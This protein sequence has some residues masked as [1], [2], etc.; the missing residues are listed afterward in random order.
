MNYG[1]NLS[2]EVSFYSRIVHG[3]VLTI[4]SMISK[5]EEIVTYIKNVNMIESKSKL[6]EISVVIWTNLRSVRYKYKTSQFGLKNSC[7]VV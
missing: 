7:V 4:V 1:I 2:T 5:L 6:L 3:S